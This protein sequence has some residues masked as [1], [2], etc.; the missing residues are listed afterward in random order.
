M[1]YS[2][3]F[4]LTVISFS[5]AKAAG[6]DSTYKY[7]LPDSVKA[8]SF[9]A[10]IQVQS[11]TTKKE[12]VAGIKTEQ[13]KLSLKANKK[14][15]EVVFE[16]PG[17]AFV[18]AKGLSIEGDEKGELEWK[19]EWATDVT[20]KLLLSAA[21]DSAGNFVLYSG[22]IFLPKE[23]K[24]KLI[25][26]CKI[27]GQWSTIQ[28]PEAFYTGKKNKLVVTINDAWIQRS[29]GSWK[30][31]QANEPVAPVVNVL[32]HVDSL[33]QFNI[34]KEIIQQHIA[35]G[36]IDTKENTEG[37]YYKILQQGTGRRISVD[38]TVSVFYK[39]T[40]LNDT[41][42]V[43]QA[44]DKPATFPLKRL[45]KGWQIGVPLLNVGG[46]IRLVIPSAH[47]YSIRTRA[48]KIPPNSILVFDIEVV[49]A[50]SPQ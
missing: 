16:F 42:I 26:T 31:L 34:D 20:Y 33:Q 38:D 10:S 40:L 21:A 17:S 47:A 45:I 46:K 6:K 18:M 11:V 32:S 36:K 14:G 5:V 39:L 29:N 9:I 19:Y 41:V 30:N 13:V 8:V 25:G 24:W 3:F 22:Y 48:A 12:V 49:D 27:A 28:K 1:K 35:A 37:V 2:L 4:V 43:D 23:N 7:D 44:K 15:R 50:K